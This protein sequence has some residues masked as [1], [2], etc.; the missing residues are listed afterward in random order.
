[1]GNLK[2]KDLTK[3]GYT[4]NQLISLVLGIASKHFKHHSNDQLIG[5]LTEIKN[6]PEEYL[7][8]EVAGK[9]AEKIIGKVSEPEFKAFELK[10]A[11]APYKIYG[12]KEIEAIARISVFLARDG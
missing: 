10:T 9:I 1:M 5:L 2:T 11:P 6:N 7:H 8:D 3:I 12:G 4:N